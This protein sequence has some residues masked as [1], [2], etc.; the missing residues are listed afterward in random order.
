MKILFICTG[1]LCRSPMAE[2]LLR[3]ELRKRR[4]RGIKVAS[5]GTWAMNGNSASADAISTL[6]SR[7]VDL[8]EH[9]SRSLVIE[10]LE[11]ADLIVAMTSVHVREIV[12]LSPGVERK[13]RLLKE[14]DKL[15]PRQVGGT[16]SERLAGMLAVAR[17]RRRRALDVDDPMGLPISSYER[18]VSELE[19]GI[20]ALADVLCGP[21]PDGGSS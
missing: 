3:Y 17:P 6:G 13:I 18:C 14:L 1:N 16:E 7:G 5:A 9:R 20:R 8:S 2:A 11:A 12:A 10:E 4:C 15:V 21:V 19:T